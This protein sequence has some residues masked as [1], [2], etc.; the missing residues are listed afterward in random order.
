MPGEFQNTSKNIPPVKRKSF[1]LFYVEKS[2]GFVKPENPTI[3]PY[4]QET[5]S[6]RTVSKL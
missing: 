5:H 4:T 6:V 2:S 1:R 3:T